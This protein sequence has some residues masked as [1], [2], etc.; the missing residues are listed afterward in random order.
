[1][2]KVLFLGL[3]LFSS[4]FLF[5]QDKEKEFLSYWEGKLKIGATEL[6][7]VV[8]VF[9][10]DDQSLGAFL[11]SPDQGQKN[12][13]VSTIEITSDSMKFVMNNIGVK[14]LGKF[15]DDK[16]KI[17]GT[18][19]Q[20]GMNLPLELKKVEKVSEVKHPQ[21]PKRPFPYN[22][23]EITFFN[24]EENI[25]LAGTLT[26]PKEGKLFPAVILV[27]GSGPQDRDESLLGH[28]PFL[29]ISDYLT[30][31][32]IAVLRYDD[33][34]VGKSTGNFST[35]TTVDF[36]NDALAAVEYLKTR[37]EIN[38]KKIGI[39]GH[40]EGGLIAPM[41]AAN[42]ND[43]A[44]I[45]LLAGPG[46]RGK[47]ILELQNE[48]IMRANGS[49][50]DEIKKSLSQSKKIYQLIIDEVDSSSIYNKLVEMYNEEFSKM[51]D[52][53]KKKPEN[54]KEYFERQA[55]TVLS[56]W[57]RFFIK[58]DP[59]PTLEQITIPVLALNGEKDLQVPPKQNLPEIE[60]AL[61]NAGNK[62]FKIVKLPK[63]NH[64][65]QPTETGSVSEYAKIETTFSE[66]TLKIIKDWIL[67]ITKN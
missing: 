15:S 26:Y 60:K 36:S 24:K 11:D 57:F 28:K 30:R 29:V 10:N 25:S 49:S 46:V 58:Y 4:S 13:P 18:F 55:K 50:E 65:F 21:N 52:E 37:K 39:I 38:P 51:T 53:E 1:M 6:T 7:L 35:A 59:R 31:N 44:F 47:E 66:D 56:P 3:V 12:I 2:K 41:C 17:E 19:Y 54:S 8:K 64:L 27:S 34:G 63:L 14:F 33:R 62:N 48:L 16:S 42:S 22:E 23:E 43:V 9:K 61:K 5:P 20:S 67:D 40:S 45:V 32:G